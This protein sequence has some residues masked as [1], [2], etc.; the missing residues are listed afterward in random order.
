[1]A[2]EGNDKDK[3]GQGRLKQKIKG[4]ERQYSQVGAELAQDEPGFDSWHQVRSS[5]PCQL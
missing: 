2:N 1:M 4:S 3:R 5:K